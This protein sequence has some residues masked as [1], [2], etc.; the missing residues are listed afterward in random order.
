MNYRMICIYD[1]LDDKSWWQV[2][3]DTI[4][5]FTTI[6]IVSDY[7]MIFSLTCLISISKVNSVR[8]YTC[9]SLFWLNYEDKQG[10]D[11]GYT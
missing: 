11:K 7:G 5:I 1:G 10:T 4:S 9:F 6:L 3:G 2:H 8:Q